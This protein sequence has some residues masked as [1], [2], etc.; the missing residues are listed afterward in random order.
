MQ[1]LALNL[2]L[3]SSLMIATSFNI[4]PKEKIKWISFSELQTQYAANPKPIIV[5]LYTSWC[6]WCKQMDR[7]TYSNPKVAAYINEHYYA[8]KYD[9]ESREPVVFNGISYSYNNTAKTNDLAL[10]L[11]FGQREYPNTVFLTSLSARPAPLSGYMKT[12][13]MEAP[14]RYFIEKVGEETFIEFNKRMKSMF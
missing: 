6:G 9:A 10:Y 14:L 2:V 7:T 4:K 12:K 3:L 5:D 8:V 11:S 13:E 1:K